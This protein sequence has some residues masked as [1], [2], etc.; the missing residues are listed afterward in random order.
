[1]NARKVEIGII[2]AAATIWLPAVWDLR[3]LSDDYM[4]IETWGQQQ[5]LLRWLTGESF[6]YVRPIASLVWKPGATIA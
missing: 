3:F 6:H 2:V 5:N 1:M 4:L